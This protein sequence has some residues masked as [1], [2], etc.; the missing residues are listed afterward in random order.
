MC[1]LSKNGVLS[2]LNNRDYDKS[3]EQHAVEALLILAFIFYVL[4]VVISFLTYLTGS[5]HKILVVFAGLLG[6]LGG[7]DNVH[8]KGCICQVWVI[9]SANTGRWTDVVD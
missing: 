5:T 3:G 8:S 1:M 4:G 2:G 6:G 7:E 9:G